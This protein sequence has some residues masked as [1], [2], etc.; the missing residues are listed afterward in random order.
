MSDG[1]KTRRQKVSEGKEGNR[2]GNNS[3]KKESKLNQE[4]KKISGL[5]DDMKQ[6]PNKRPKKGGDDD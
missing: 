4:L 6:N 1:R 2:E 3:K 5:M